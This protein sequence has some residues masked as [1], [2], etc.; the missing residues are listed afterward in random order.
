MIV[1]KVLSKMGKVVS[2]D[3]ERWRHVLEHPEMNNQLDRI[4]ETIMSP[5][6]VIESVHDPTI[7]LF[8]KL[9]KETSV[10]EK[11][12]L[13]IIKALNREGFIVTAFFTDRVKKGE[14]VWKK[15]P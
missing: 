3:E 13:A 12:L 9:Y 8:Y 11:Y 4:K 6:E 7:L 2:L 10:T 14:V 1:F 5:D 15:K